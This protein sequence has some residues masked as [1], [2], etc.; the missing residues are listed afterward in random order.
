VKS[1]YLDSELCALNADGVP[2]SITGCGWL[3]YAR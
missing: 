2:V 3:P 1:A